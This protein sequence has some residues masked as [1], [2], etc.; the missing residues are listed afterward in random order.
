[1]VDCTLPALRFLPISV[2]IDNLG[3]DSF[4][5]GRI[6][7]S[8]TISIKPMLLRYNPQGSVEKWGA[9]Q[10]QSLLSLTHTSNGCIKI[11]MYTMSVKAL[12]CSNMM[13]SMQRFTS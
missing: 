10:I 12:P 8:L 5:E 1:M 6:L 11:A 4:I 9:N 13:N 3:W 2:D 7:Y